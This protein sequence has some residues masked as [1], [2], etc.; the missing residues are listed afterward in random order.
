MKLL[1][2]RVT[3]HTALAWEELKI[4]TKLSTYCVLFL[5]C[6]K[7]KITTSAVTAQ[8]IWTDSGWNA[9]LQLLCED[10]S[11]VIGLHLASSE[12]ANVFS[13]ACAWLC[14]LPS[15]T[16]EALAP[17]KWPSTCRCQ[18]SRLL[19]DHTH[20]VCVVSL[21]PF[22]SSWLHRPWSRLMS[23][24]TIYV[25]VH[26][27]SIIGFF[28]LFFITC[29]LKVLTQQWISFSHRYTW[30]A[31]VPSHHFPSQFLRSCLRVH[32]HPAVILLCLFLS[33]KDLLSFSWPSF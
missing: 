28:L 18:G 31:L 14:I 21:F 3:Y 13:K 7:I 16:R 32:F 5:Q 19:V 23:L 10:H 29:V 15:D 33:C 2:Q 9:R 26:N 8:D 17:C 11:Q 6:Y 30:F 20:C 27:V 22:S 1:H 24:G 12:I 25:T 4:W